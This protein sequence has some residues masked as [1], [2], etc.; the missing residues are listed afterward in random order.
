V[1]IEEFDAGVGDGQGGGGEVTVVLEVEEVVADLMFGEAVG[2]S[3]VVIGEHADGAGVGVLCAG[4]EAG[5]LEILGHAPT[6]CGGH[7]TV[8]SQEGEV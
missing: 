6:E 2:R 8:L 1:R 7:G 4:A 3:M 5:D